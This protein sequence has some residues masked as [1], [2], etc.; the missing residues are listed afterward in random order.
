MRKI[1]LAL[2]VVLA[3]ATAS[4]G[5]TLADFSDIEP[6]HDNYINT[7]SLDLK[8]AVADECWVPG[9]FHDDP[10]LDLA[11]AVDDG[12]ICETYGAN[13]LLR[14]AGS[15]AGWFFPGG[16]AKCGGPVSD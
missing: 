10:Q 6:S 13:L 2:I 5:S 15:G 12:Q 1:V 4:V 16:R 11:M 3:I 14:N 8:V 7:G 9:V